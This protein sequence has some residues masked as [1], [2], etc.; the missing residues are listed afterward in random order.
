MFIVYSPEGQSFIGASQK[1]SPLKVDPVR[2]MRPLDDGVTERGRELLDVAFK[3][4]KRHGSTQA[5]IH[6]Y[7]RTQKSLT[8]RL[9]VNVSEIMSHPVI[10]VEAQSQLEEAWQLMQAHG[11]QHLPVMQG[12]KLVG[13]CSQRDLLNRMI[14]S[15]EGVLEG[16]KRESIA[17]IMQDHVVT[18]TQE[19]D[20]RHVASIL[21]QYDIGALV[22]M[23]Q[24]ETPVGIVTRG[25]I[26][27]RLGNDP[28]L[29]LYV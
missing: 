14:V 16:V 25:D 27:K 11:F 17:E 7:Q 24:Y 15:K 8:R 22:I 23:D 3:S 20:I 10:V 12:G 26:I 28:P 19:T 9:V 13:I 18:T 6:A 5:A 1:P 4:R 29:E 2:A 21:S